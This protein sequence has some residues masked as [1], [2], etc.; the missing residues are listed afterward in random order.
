MK[1][2]YKLAFLLHLICLPLISAST[3][4][5]L[6][7]ASIVTSENTVRLDESCKI[8]FR[9]SGACA[10]TKSSVNPHCNLHTQ[11]LIQPCY[12]MYYDSALN[13]S[14][15]GHCYYS[16]YE[17]QGKIIEITTSEE[18]NAKICSQYGELKRTNRFCGQCADTYGLAAYSYH[19]FTC[20]PCKDYDYRNWLQYFAVALLPLTVFYILAVLLSFNVTSSSLNGLVLVI[21]CTMSPIQLLLIE[22]S[23]TLMHAKTDMFLVKVFSSI[24]G[25]LNLDFFR[26][27]YPPFCLHPK[28]NVFAI[29]SLDYLVALYPFLLIFLTYLLVTAHDK[30]YRLVVWMWRP[31]KMCVHCHRNTWNIRTSLIEIFAT[32]ILLSYVKIL[33]VSLQILSFTPTYD[34]AGNKLKH[35]Y[36]HFDGTVEYFGHT[37]LPYAVL[38]LAMISIFVFLPF[39]LLAVYPRRYWTWQLLCVHLHY[40]CL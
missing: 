37:H 19:L 24:F 36:T 27:V 40:I 21:Q 33:G 23:P 6:E 34:V 22:G 32:F 39:L 38:A 29:F 17:Y 14:I 9:D 7:S 28:A 10:S 15:V 4:G 3:K 26:L 18:F 5:T 31:L 25:L 1:T 8:R 35:Y 30:R 20:I 2:Q 11:I 13:L 16:C 12:C